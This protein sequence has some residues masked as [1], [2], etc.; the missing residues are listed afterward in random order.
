MRYGVLILALL[1]T[2]PAYAQRRD[3]SWIIRAG[4]FEGDTVH[5]DLDL[6][7]RRKTGFLRVSRVKSNARY[8][9]WNPSRLPAAVAFKPGRGITAQDS[10]AFWSILNQMEREIGLTLFKPATLDTDAD[11][12]DMIVVDV[13]AMRGNDGMTL[14]TW[15]TSGGVYDARVYFRS[16]GTLHNPR[17]VAHEL[18]HSL[19]F[20]HT[21][22]WGS[23]MNPDPWSAS[24][25][26]EDVAYAQYAFASRASSERDDMWERLALADERE[27]S[28]RRPENFAECAAVNSDNFDEIPMTKI[29]GLIAL[30]TLSAIAACNNGAERNADTS[31]SAAVQVDSAA[32]IAAPDSSPSVTP[33]AAPVTT[34]P[35]NAPGASR[36]RQPVAPPLAPQRKQ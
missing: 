25:T 1:I 33:P 11:P 24:L 12:E 27:G 7:S 13:K 4:T 18:M 6:A 35:A 5:L 19:G 2:V 9:G 21:T 30:G 31:A 3:S 10:I 34:L 28:G 20:G 26:R 22:A 8:V 29:R 17:V 15:S 16:S 14:V 32:A 36:P 23:I